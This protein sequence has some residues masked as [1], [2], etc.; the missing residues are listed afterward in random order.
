M[1]ESTELGSITRYLVGKVTSK[2][3]KYHLQ[4][5]KNCFIG[6]E[7]VT[8]MVDSGLV[9]SRDEAVQLGKEMLKEGLLKH[10]TDDN[11]FEDE[12]LFYRFTMLE[13]PRGHI[14]GHVS[15]ADF[16]DTNATTKVSFSGN[17]DNG[18]R[19]MDEEVSPLDEHN[20]KLLDLVKPK[21]WVDPVPLD[22]YNLVVI[23][24][25]AGGL[26]SAIQSA[27]LQG[28]VALIEKHLLGG[29]CLNVGC[30]PSKALIRC[31]RAVKEMKN[32]E[33]FGIE[34]EGKANVNFGRIM[35]RMRRLRAKIAPA[36]S[37][38]RYTGLGVNVFQGHAR[39]TS[40]NTVEVNGKRLKFAKCIIATGARAFVPPIP[41]LKEVPY[42]TNSSLFNLTELPEVFGVIGSGPIGVEMAQCFA[43]FGSKVVLFDLMEKILPREDP[44]AASI[45]QSA[46][47][48][49]G[50]EF[51]FKSM[52]SKVDYDTESK[53]ITMTFTQDGGSAQT[54]TLDQLLVS[55]GRAPNV[56]ELDLEKAGVEYKTKGFRGLVVKDTLQTTNPK[57]YGVGDVC[58]PYQ[59][60]HMADASAKIAFRNSMFPVVSEKVSK[61]I[62]PW[63]TY[64]SPEISH[65]GAYEKELDEKD[66]KYEVWIASLEHN[67]RAILEGDNDGF[68]KLISKAGTDTILGATI[69]AENAGDMI[70]EVSVAMQAGMG[71]KALS[72][73]IHPY[74]TQADA[75]RIAAGGFNKTR[76]TPGTKRLLKTIISLRN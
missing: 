20:I 9:P 62:I 28:K 48:E 71:L 64:T 70:S 6:S 33:E 15:W 4:T 43:R 32:A 11:D 66:I 2:D 31:A 51:R 10:V 21:S 8:E 46:L 29:D 60:T 40:K 63:C 55:A 50:V 76:L 47:E 61:L 24:A 26:I 41:G 22:K 69:V 39:F 12:R 7:A 23:G 45:I 3:R 1:A 5:F 27:G 36:D 37:A 18:E 42:L 13:T 56:E 65:V 25:G 14:E 34:I 74:P 35:E 57:I 53:K 59:F 17:I 54:I 16:K 49:D 52:I 75:I 38:K 58:L 19:E 73:V 67:D 30:V 68:V 44:D 72:T